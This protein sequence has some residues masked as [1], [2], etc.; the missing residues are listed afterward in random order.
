MEITITARQDNPLLERQE[1]KGHLAFT[2]ST[3]SNAQ[4]LEQ[5]AKEMHADP[6][7]IIIDQIKTVFG[8]Q[9]AGFSAVAYK[10]AEAKNKFA[11]IP[12]HLKK[13]EK[14]EKKGEQPQNK[15]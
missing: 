5:L 2:G 9:Q 12:S 15:K 14:G 11:V 1:I 6:T 10:S 3:P 7:V 13:K 4:L 8:K